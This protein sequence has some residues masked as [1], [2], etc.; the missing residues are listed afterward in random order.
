MV[1]DDTQMPFGKH[2]GTK[3]KDV[4]S[5]Y[6]DW[7]HGQFWVSDWPTVLA[8]IEKMRDVIDDDLRS[9]GLID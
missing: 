4:P 7:L 1:S 9:K 5:D 2:K 3:M 8:Y 6:L